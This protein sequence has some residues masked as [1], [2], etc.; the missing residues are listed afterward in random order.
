MIWLLSYQDIFYVQ[1]L[2]HE[3]FIHLTN[4][5]LSNKDDSL[6]YHNLTTKRHTNFFPKIMQM[7]PPPKFS[8]D[9]VFHVSLMSQHS[10]IWM[11][12]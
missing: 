11:A 1:L 3:P 5:P 2:I 6:P 4:S 7:T 8:E 10:F 12:F 9:I